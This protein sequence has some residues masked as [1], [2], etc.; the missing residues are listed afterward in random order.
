MAR[1]ATQFHPKA[2]PLLNC[3]QFLMAEILSADLAA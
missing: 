3:F 2:H 1:F